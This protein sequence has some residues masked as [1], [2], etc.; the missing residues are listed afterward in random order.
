MSN[1]AI[2]NIAIVSLSSGILGEPFIEFEKDIGVRRLKEFGLNVKFMPHALSGIEY[3]KI[4]PKQERMTLLK[5]LTIPK[6]T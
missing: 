2:K 6:Q 1:K 5:H 4:I 3:I